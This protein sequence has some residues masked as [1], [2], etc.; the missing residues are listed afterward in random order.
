[1]PIV[2]RDFLDFRDRVRANPP[3]RRPDVLLELQYE[4]IDP[5]LGNL[6]DIPMM[7]AASCCVVA[8]VR[9]FP[10]CGP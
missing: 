3:I 9:A 5:P 4:A 1:M 2:Y 10:L 7:G 6:Y 8:E